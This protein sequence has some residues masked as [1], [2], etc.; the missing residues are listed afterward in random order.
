MKMKKTLAVFL[1]VFLVLT[2]FSVCFAAGNE[3]AVI[4]LIPGDVIDGKNTLIVAAENCLDLTMCNLTIGYD[5]AAVEFVQVKQQYGTTEY[6]ESLGCFGIL[7]LK[8]EFF[9]ACNNKKDDGEFLL[10]FGFLNSLNPEEL[11]EDFD[12][13]EVHLFRLYY[14]I[15][16]E[17]ISAV[18]FSLEGDAGFIGRNDLII[19]EKCEIKFPCKPG[20][21]TDENFDRICEV[22]STEYEV[23]PGDVNFDGRVDAAD[24]RLA[25]RYSAGAE[26]LTDAQLKIADVYKE[27]NNPGVVNSADARRIYRASIAKDVIEEN[28][29]D[30]ILKDVSSRYDDA[31]YLQVVNNSHDSL[32]V[33]VSCNDIDDV[34]SFDSVIKY[35]PTL[36][37]VE[38]VAA[39][40]SIFP[41]AEKQHSAYE[42]YFDREQYF[43][44]SYD[45][46]VAGEVK[47]SGGFENTS[48]I[49]GS[50]WLFYFGLNKAAVSDVTTADIELSVNMYLAD[51]NEFA[52]CKNNISPQFTVEK[53]DGI[54][55]YMGYTYELT[56]G[57]AKIIYHDDFYGDVIIPE[58][59]DGY[60]VTGIDGRF[61][62]NS[63]L[64]T[65][66]IPSHIE[67]IGTI[68]FSEEE[69]IDDIEFIFTDII[70]DENNPYYSSV[71]GVLFNKD[72]T[73]LLLYPTGRRDAS[74]TVP[75]TVRLIDVQ[76]FAY[77]YFI[78]EIV[79]SE[80]LSEINTAA[81]EGCKSLKFITLPESVSFIAYHAFGSCSAI[82]T[83]YFGGDIISWANWNG[84]S[85]GNDY[86]WNANVVCA[87]EA[88]I[89]IESNSVKMSSEGYILVNAEKNIEDL[90]DELN[91][92][93]FVNCSVNIVN[94]TGES[95]DLDS[96]LASGMKL[97]IKNLA[98]DEIFSMTIVVPCD[99]DGDAEIS[100][101]DART[102]LRNSVGLDELSE[103]QKSAADIDSDG[104]VAS[105]DARLILRASVGLENMSELFEKL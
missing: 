68:D 11:K 38:A 66:Y 93:L 89:I 101:A 6:T 37:T 69:Y 82:D 42:D 50:Q 10:N 63:S 36:F 9:S 54:Y 3:N 39:N 20:E 31:L 64:R 55:Q 92:N 83:V 80:G 72:K 15:L 58:E 43:R 77:N 24:S 22:C 49:D 91:R 99:I 79:M 96:K 104:V 105:A 47:F 32:Y 53:T 40:H 85:L 29:E 61:L 35:D 62:S 60:P 65:I 33:Y 18:E 84:A 73:T 30:I 78:E 59:I 4:R 23:E 2:Q 25:Y 88:E 8:G 86:L 56:D 71:D 103:W 16:S 102:A 21:H 81:F 17:N 74:Y 75:D 44:Y 95:I 12:I 13:A 1:S 46:S 90:F 34:T 52:V 100:A 7:G 41:T 87:K 94:N 97:T 28:G 70:V 76:A 5:N 67:D 27:E 51:N 98:G 57:K 45:T 19:D 26:D 14:N 48:E